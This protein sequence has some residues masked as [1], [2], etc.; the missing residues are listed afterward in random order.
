MPSKQN[1]LLSYYGDDLTGSTDVMEALSLSGIPTVLFLAVPDADLL[2]RFADRQAIGIAGTSRSETPEW[3][4]ENLTPV[5]EWLRSLNALLCHY[6]VCSTFDSSLAVGNIGRAIEIGR[7]VFAQQTVPLIVGAPQLK[8]YTAFANLFAAYRGTFYRIDRHPVMSKHP[9]TPM[10]EA[11]L[12]IHLAQQTDLR[13]GLVDLADL[14]ASDLQERVDHEDADILLFDVADPE[15]QRLAGR[16]V[17]RR[18]GSHG[19]FIAGSSGVEYA[20]LSAL[21]DELGPQPQFDPLGAVDRL[22][23]VSGSVSPTTENQIRHA[24]SKGFEAIAVDPVQ[25]SGE[26]GEVT[27]EAAFRAGLAVLEQGRSVILYT[28]L[29][30]GADRGSEIDSSSGARHR[31]GRALGDILKGLV[32]SAGLKRAVIAGGDTSSH[33]LGRLGVE[34]LTVRMPLPETPGSPLCRAH[35]RDTDIDGLEIAMKGGQIGLDDYF[36]RMRDGL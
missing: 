9:V 1:P 7:R 33:A 13:C 12:R 20:I 5:F 26:N 21:A 34:A 3:M 10:R 4:D 23:V 2:A 15:S 6:K 29:G 18:A 28:A 19:A 31:L 22:A 25:L 17:L 27:A 36:C 35:S 8:R 11:D 16:E 14:R 24:A 30:P 32:L